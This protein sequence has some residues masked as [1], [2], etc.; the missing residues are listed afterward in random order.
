MCAY[1]F[2]INRRS[3]KKKKRRRNNKLKMRKTEDK[4]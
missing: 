4:K 3:S 2:L 1:T